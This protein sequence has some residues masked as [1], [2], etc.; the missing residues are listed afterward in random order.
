MGNPYQTDAADKQQQQQ[1]QQQQQDATTQHEF[2]EALSLLQANAPGIDSLSISIFAANA[3]LV[4][5]T[6]AEGARRERVRA[7]ALD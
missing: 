1:Q 4:A 6:H 3:Y 5:L 7:L 2:N